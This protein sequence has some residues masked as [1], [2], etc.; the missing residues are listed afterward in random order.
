MAY[1]LEESLEQISI[2]IDTYESGV[3][4]DQEG[5]RIIQ[6]DLAIHNYHL[7]K[8]NIEAYQ[9]FNTVLFNRGSKSVAA[10]K[11]EADEEVPELRMLRKIMGSVD[12][13]LWS[14]RSEISIIK[15]EQ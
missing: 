11:V 14:I 12:Q 7:T 10:A 8:Y 3:W 5:L 15:K 6:R 2:I 13:V 9:K 4:K 1:S